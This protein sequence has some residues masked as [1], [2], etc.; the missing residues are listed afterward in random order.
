MVNW[1]ETWGMADIEY[2]VWEDNGAIGVG[3]ADG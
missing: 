3:N 1:V 2:S